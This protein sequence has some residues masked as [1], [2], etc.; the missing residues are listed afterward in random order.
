[1]VPIPNWRL[2]EGGVGL[3]LK[4]LFEVEKIDFVM[5]AGANLGQYHDF[6]REFI[7]YRG[8]IAS[9]EPNMDLVSLL[10]D[11]VKKDPSWPILGVALGPTEGSSNVNVMEDRQFSSW[12]IR[13]RRRTSLKFGRFLTHGRPP[14]Q[15]PR[16]LP[17][18]DIRP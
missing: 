4:R 9:F 12:L 6:L 2:A 8:L 18:V 3:H 10:R 15:F 13:L 17:V 5:D 7:D 11:R 16:R 1:M 14:E